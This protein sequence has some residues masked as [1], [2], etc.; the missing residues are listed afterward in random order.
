MHDTVLFFFTHVGI[1]TY[2]EA[3]SAI[4][5]LEIIFYITERKIIKYYTCIEQT[6]CISSA[7][8]YMMHVISK[9]IGQM[10]IWYARACAFIM[11]AHSAA[12]RK[13]KQL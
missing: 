7:Q 5:F 3:F 2:W 11:R 9:L 8:L 6:F 12:S 10:G 13:V 1:M 4:F